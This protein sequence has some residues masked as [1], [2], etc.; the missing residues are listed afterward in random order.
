MAAAAA[1][2]EG[3]MPSAHP[4][5]VER[6]TWGRDACSIRGAAARERVYSACGKLKKPD[7]SYWRFTFVSR[8]AAAP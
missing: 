7:G 8:P 4:R 3:F 5:A 2:R 1:M 6:A